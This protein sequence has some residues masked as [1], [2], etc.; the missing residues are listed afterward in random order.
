MERYFVDFKVHNAEND[1][2]AYKTELNTDDFDKAIVKFHE[3]CKTYV[4]GNTFDHVL[5]ILSNA[6]GISLK[7]EYWTKK[8]NVEVEE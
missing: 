5:V 6:Q 7:S 8:A 3:V 2:W 1:G 4:G